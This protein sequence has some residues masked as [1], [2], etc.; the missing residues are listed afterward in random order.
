MT[1]SGN[2]HTHQK[3]RHS[4]VRLVADHTLLSALAVM[5]LAPFLFILL[6]SF[7]TARQAGT[8]DWWPSTWQFANY[9]T[10][11]EK[12][13][14]LKYFGNSFLYAGLAT[15]FMLA[16][17]VPAAYALSRIRFRGSRVIFVIIICAMLLPPQVTTV[18]LYV[19]WARLHLTGSL[20]PLILPNLLGDAFSVFL[21]RQFLLTIPKEYSE[22]A[23]LDGCGEFRTML[24]VIVPMAKPGIAAAAIFLF[25]HA[26]NDYYGA[27]LYTSENENAWPISYALAQFRGTRSV[28]W[29]LVM[30]ATV[31]AMIPVIL[32]FFAAQK[33]FVQGVTLTGVKG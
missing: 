19:M 5:F 4:V 18:P 6:T 24:R 3:R 14:V 20:W 23:K 25:F 13:D 28:D 31:L 26:W 9:A 11:F 7:M 8:R 29:N 22:S 32:I 17:S 21:L 33:V 16:S 2:R 15:I 1:Q 30:A 27:L 12:L 10:V